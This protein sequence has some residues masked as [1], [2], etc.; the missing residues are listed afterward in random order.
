MLHWEGQPDPVFNYGL[1]AEKC[2]AISLQ[3]FD[4]RD[5]HVAENLRTVQLDSVDFLS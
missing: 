3:G 5:T 4:C 2:P 1:R